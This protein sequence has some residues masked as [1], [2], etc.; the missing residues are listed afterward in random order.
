MEGGVGEGWIVRYPSLVG[1]QIVLAPAS[2]LA[3]VVRAAWVERY[4]RCAGSGEGE[5]MRR[6][7]KL[8]GQDSS[9][10]GVD[11]DTQCGVPIEDDG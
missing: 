10:N 2:S 6:S 5:P 9:G 8:L 11:S 1:V 7:R 3:D 4:G